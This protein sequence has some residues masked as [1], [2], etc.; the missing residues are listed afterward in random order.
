[1]PVDKFVTRREPFFILYEK[2]SSYT[3]VSIFS[4][5]GSLELIKDNL[6]ELLKDEKNKDKRSIL[7]E[8]LSKIKE[9]QDFVELTN[10]GFKISLCLNPKPLKNETRARYEY[11]AGGITDLL[12]NYPNKELQK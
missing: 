7:L 6:K 5:G 9:K 2:I 3:H 1:M 8:A 12:L 4:A 11:S 10:S